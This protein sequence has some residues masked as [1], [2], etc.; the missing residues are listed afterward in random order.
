[1]E[2]LPVP[3]TP[4]EELDTP[5]IIIDLPTFE[6]N[7][8]KLHGY[9]GQQTCKVRPHVKTPKSPAVA[10]IQ[11]AAGGTT[12]GI[13]AAKVGEAEAMVLG[14]IR[15]VLIANQVIGRPKVQRLM[16]LAR[17]ADLMVCVDS[18]ANVDELSQA[19]Q[20]FGATLGCLV[21]VNVGLNRCGVEP[22]IPALELARHVARSPG[23]RFGGLSGYEGGLAA[24]PDFEERAIETKK[25]IQLLLDTRELLER[26]GLP[27]EI[28]SA[29]GT[30]TWNITGAIEGVTE[31]QVGS[32]IFMDTRYRYC[33]D[34]DIS[35]KVLAMVI[36]RP[37]KGVAVIDC[38]HKGIGLNASAALPYPLPNFNG[39]PE[40]EFPRGATVNRLT[41]EHGILD[42]EDEEA[43]QLRVGDKVVLLPAFH[44]ATINQYDY[45]FG[46]R[47]G[48]VEIVWP[49]TARGASR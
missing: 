20:A 11:I 34:F 26:G 12:G 30:A 36:S 15:Q 9:F 14:G 40:V 17:Y 2:F 18:A 19:T 37:R 1:M 3:G 10:H 48:R 5:A 25:R 4:V 42:L 47:D 27:V 8:F 33:P 21:E 22:G 16:Q 24:F 29:G 13:C 28:A 31:V 23:L 39:L 38:G 32:Y 41:G 44:E 35:C 43:E 46:I 7:I 49:I 6:R 45:M